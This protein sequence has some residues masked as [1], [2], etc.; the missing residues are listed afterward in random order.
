[1][2]VFPSKVVA[3]DSATGVAVGAGVTGVGVATGSG[4]TGTGVAVGDAVP[5]HA[6]TTS[7][8]VA[9]RVT[10]RRMTHRLLLLPGLHPPGFAGDHA[11][12]QLAFD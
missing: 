3:A 1:V 4:V 5:L 12:P 2:H 8:S 6:A 9:M 7:T 10:E 11:S